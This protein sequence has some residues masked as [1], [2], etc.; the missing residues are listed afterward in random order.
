MQ[1]YRTRHLLAKLTQFVDMAYKGLKMPGSLLVANGASRL[2]KDIAQRVSFGPRRGF[3]V[4]PPSF[5]KD[6]MKYGYART[7][8]RVASIN[9]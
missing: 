8:A 4:V 7:A 3:P 1:Q 2:G 5:I 6:G 9:L